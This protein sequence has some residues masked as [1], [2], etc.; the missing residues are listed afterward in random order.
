MELPPRIK[1]RIEASRQNVRQAIDQ[2][3]TMAAEEADHMA[4]LTGAAKA[5]FEANYC[6]WIRSG[7]SP[8]EAMMKT[9]M[10]WGPTGDLLARHQPDAPFVLPANDARSLPSPR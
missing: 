2:Q 6:H 10:A 4:V 5:L 3:L 7:H 9:R 8:Q 1:H